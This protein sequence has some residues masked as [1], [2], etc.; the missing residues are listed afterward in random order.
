VYT[1]S[2]LSQ[3]EETRLKRF[4]RS[5]IL[6]DARS[7]ERLLA[8]TT[9]F[10]HRVE[11]ELP[12]PKRRMLQDAAGAAPAFRGKQVR[13][14]DDDVKNIYALSSVLE[15]AGMNVVFA[16]NGLAGIEMLKQNPGISIVLMDVMMPEMDGYETMRRIRQIPA[17]KSLPVLAL[18]AKAMKGD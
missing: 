8:E 9:L 5:I 17:Y 16:E 12:Q 1:G 18:T 10:L 14:V 2:D 11:A 3:Q 4:A 7:P 13:S 15:E 6:K